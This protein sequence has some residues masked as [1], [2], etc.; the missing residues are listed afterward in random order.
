LRIDDT[1]YLIEI[2][3]LIKEL[4]RLNRLLT[5]KFPEN[6]KTSNA[7]L[8]LQKHL[9]TFLHRFSVHL[10]TGAAGLLILTVAAL[11]HQAGVGQDLL[12]ELFS[13]VGRSK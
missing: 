1:D 10:G 13:L 5:R 11:L 9:D 4:R 8:D 2:R 3:N 12:K 6:H 7:V